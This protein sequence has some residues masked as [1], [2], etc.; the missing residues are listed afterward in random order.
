V[1]GVPSADACCA[2]CSAHAGCKFWTWNGPT[3]HDC[4][5]KTTDAGA[6]PAAGHVSG[7]QAPAALFHQDLGDVNCWETTYTD[8][9]YVKL[10]W[11]SGACP[12]T[13]DCQW[14]VVSTAHT[15]ICNHHSEENLKYCATSQVTIL[16]TKK[17]CFTDDMVLA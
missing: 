7:P 3:N 1:E 6:G 5:L 9:N 2:A 17:G 12:N 13:P 16:I 10:G 15:T 8:S 4:W 14:K 11:T